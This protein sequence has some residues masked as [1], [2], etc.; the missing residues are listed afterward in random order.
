MTHPRPRATPTPPGA[1]PPPTPKPIPAPENPTTVSRRNRLN[2]FRREVSTAF[3]S[4]KKEATASQRNLISGVQP[5][6]VESIGTVGGRAVSGRTFFPAPGK[7]AGIVTGAIQATGL[8]PQTG[9][10]ISI[11]GKDPTISKVRHET[12]HAILFKQGVPSGA[13]HA[14][15]DRSRDPKGQI[16]LPSIQAAKRATSG[17]TARGRNEGRQVLRKRQAV[18]AKRRR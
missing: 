4:V 17:S 18:L 3:S 2:R 16:N 6:A 7:T 11:Q 8:I 15:L 5:K 9:I 12:A 13:Q 10:Q 1:G 14:I